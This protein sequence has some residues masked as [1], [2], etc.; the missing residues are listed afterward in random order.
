MDLG[1]KRGLRTQCG[2][3]TFY[4]LVVTNITW[5]IYKREQNSR[6]HAL[7]DQLIY[8]RIPLFPPP[9]LPTPQSMISFSGRRDGPWL[10]RS[11]PERAVRLGALVEDIG[12]FPF[13]KRFRKIPETSV[14]TV[15]RWRTRSIWHTR[16]VPFTPRL[17]TPSDA[18]SSQK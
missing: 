7:W 9:P 11:S 12:R 14:G 8:F 5:Y 13:T 15:Y 1:I 3:P 18:Q 4:W 17:H 10:V 6:M 16:R 2:L